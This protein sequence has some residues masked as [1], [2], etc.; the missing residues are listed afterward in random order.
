MPY[1]K[2]F[3]GYIKVYILVKRQMIFKNLITLLCLSS[4]DLQ[5]QALIKLTWC[6]DFSVLRL[7]NTLHP[8]TFK[9][10]SHWTVYG[11]KKCHNFFFFFWRGLQRL[12]WHGISGAR[13]VFVC[14]SSFFSRSRHLIHFYRASLAS[15]LKLNWYRNSKIL[16]AN[17]HI[18]KL[19]KILIILIKKRSRKCGLTLIWDV[20]SEAGVHWGT[21]GLR[22]T[23]GP[24]GHRLL[25][26]KRM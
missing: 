15:S 16:L 13:F 7:L 3:R 5:K 12:H 6:F 19:E 4:K 18:F 21:G 20:R 9:P 8:G 25:G 2:K 10:R 11:S 14:L 22:G 24:V 17:T 23:G 1:I 26:F